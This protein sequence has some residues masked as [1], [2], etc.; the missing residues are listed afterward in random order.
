MKKA[1]L[2]AACLALTISFSFG[3]D[4]PA[5]NAA[6]ATN[7]TVTPAAPTAEVGAPQFQN[8][9]RICFVGDSITQLGDYESDIMLYY[10]THFPDRK[11]EGYN[12]GVNGDSMGGLLVLKRYQW[13]VLIHNPTVITLM[14]GMNDVGRDY[15]GKDKVGPDWDNKRKWPL[16]GYVTDLHKVSDIFTQANCKIIYLTPSIY[17]QTGNQ[18]AV[19]NFGVNDAL[20]ICAQDC[21]K[22]AAE[23]HAGL[24]DFYGPMTRINAEQQAKDPSFTLVGPDRIHPHGPGALVMTYLFLKAQNVPA[25]VSEMSIDGTGGTVVKQDNCAITDLKQQGGVVSFTAKENSLPFPLAALKVPDIDT[26]VPF[27]NDLDQ[28]TLTVA[29]LPAG[30]YT[31]SIDGQPVQDCTADDLKNGINLAANVNTPQYK[32]ALAVFA[33]AGKRRQLESLIRTFEGVT[34]AVV[35]AKVSLDDEAAD[36][37]VI[38]DK[39]DEVRKQNKTAPHFEIYLKYSAAE[40]KKMQS[41]A[42]DLQNQVYV[43][44]QPT[45]HTFEIRAK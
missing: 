21:F 43:A 45:P 5:T 42:A 19:N 8:G 18:A 38:Q 14:Y 4:V 41:D 7:Q 31:L 36:R 40:W 17:D 26:L 11:I 33:L 30:N 6:P 13:D 3:D 28:E 23:T 2:S 29:N 10:A 34:G 24:V 39:L 25:D 12:C 20:G 32:Q 35:Q 44:D 9:D 1:F 27:T 22:I 16:L 15:Y 37:K